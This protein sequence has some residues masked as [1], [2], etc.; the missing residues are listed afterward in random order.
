MEKYKVFTIIY[1]LSVVSSP[2]ANLLG[3]DVQ[4]FYRIPF[5][6]IRWIDIAIIYIAF[7]F[8]RSMFVSLPILSGNK[9]LIT[10]LIVYLIFEFIQFV[11]TWGETDPGW[12]VSGILCTI[13]IFILIDLAI[14]QLNRKDVI[15]FLKFFA[16]WGTITLTL[17]NAYL[18]YSFIS[19]NTVLTDLDIRVAIDVIGAKETVSTV[20]LLPFVYL[21]NLYFINKKEKPKIKLL[22]IISVF[23]IFISL[24]IRF[25]RGNLITVIFLTLIYFAFF[26]NKPSQSLKRAAGL[27]TLIIIG[28]L[29]FGRIL[30]Q[31][32]YNPIDKISQLAEFTVNTK[33][34]GWDKGRDIPIKYALDA[35]KNHL[36]I[37]VGY[38]DLYKFGL[39]EEMGAVHNFVVASLFYRG[40]I[41]TTIYLLIISLL[42]MN[43]FKYWIILKR[44]PFENNLLKIL[45]VT[46]FFWIIPFWTQ[47]IMFERYSLSIQFIYFGLIINL[48]SQ[49]KYYF[50][51]SIN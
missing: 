15:D 3:T 48:C 16:F 30:N 28:Y 32:G 37:G 41:G 13:N 2:I 12:Q 14:F 19:G 51:T 20:V 39:P 8:I 21:S 29:I 33:S 11:R 5:L 34:A 6:N 7:C 49:K 35:W 26:S 17:S 18:F 46:S 10:L 9:F 24:V 22:H 23:S 25:H 1:L 42:Y 31:K 50:K 43:C 4:N 47:D 45:V 40:I 38:V 27:I 36:W 44:K